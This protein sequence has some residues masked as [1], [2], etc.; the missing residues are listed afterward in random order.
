MAPQ[1]CG[2]L[3]L[4]CVVARVASS[5]GAVRGA[6]LAGQ[7]SVGVAPGGH[8]GAADR[9]LARVAHWALLGLLILGICCNVHAREGD[10]E[11]RGPPAPAAARPAKRAAVPSPAPGRATTAAAADDAIEGA[12]GAPPGSVA[13]DPRALAVAVD[14]DNGGGG[15]LAENEEDVFSQLLFPELED[16]SPPSESEPIGLNKWSGTHVLRVSAH[17]TD[18][19]ELLAKVSRAGRLGRA[20]GKTAAETVADIVDLCRANALTAQQ[21]RRRRVPPRLSKIRRCQH[22]HP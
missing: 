19:K 14:D 12:P 5:P 16:S 6:L 8:G 15:S 3:L 21:R 17:R 2:R 1:R 10:D 18:P 4:C 7:P 20:P 13:L 9:D 22:P 11:P